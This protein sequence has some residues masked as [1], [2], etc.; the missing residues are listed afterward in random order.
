MKN[1]IAPSL[2]LAVILIAG[3]VLLAPAPSLLNA[4]QPADQAPTRPDRLTVYGDPGNCGEGETSYSFLQHFG[5]RCIA[6]LTQAPIPALAAT[7]ANNLSVYSIGANGLPALLAGVGDS[8]LTS[9]TVTGLSALRVCHVTY[10]FAVDG[11]AT[12]IVPAGNCVIP[13]NAV[14]YNVG[15]QSTT[16]VTAVGLATVALGCTGGT[17][18]GT[19]ALMTALAKASLG[20]AAFGQ[21]VPV[22]QTASTWVKTTAAGGLALTIAT[23]PL[24]AGIIEIYCEYY[25]SSS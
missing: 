25:L 3:A 15:I 6:A 12:P 17:A 11:G 8:N 24:T 21:S 23:G 2:F 1:Y 22:P 9:N 16:A 19:A 14:I 7:S 13:A 18:C 4:Q 5:K 10:S 20:T